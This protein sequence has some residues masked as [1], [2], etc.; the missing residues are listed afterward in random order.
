MGL[1]GQ[2]KIYFLNKDK[3]VIKSDD[4][5][6]YKMCAGYL[7]LKIEPNA[8]YV[9]VC[10][11]NDYQSCECIYCITAEQEEEQVTTKQEKEEEEVTTEQEE[12]EATAE[13]DEPQSKKTKTSN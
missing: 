10:F 7:Q 9:Q 8:E 1:D 5:T 11:S 12:E 13:E 6:C 2:V 3:N 4:F